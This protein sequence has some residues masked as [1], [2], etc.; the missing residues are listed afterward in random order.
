MKTDRNEVIT[1]SDQFLIICSRG[2]KW[3]AAQKCTDRDSA[4]FC[5][6]RRAA[7]N[8][9]CFK[10]Q[11]QLKW[12]AARLSFMAIMLWSLNLR[13]DL[14]RLPGVIT[15]SA[16]AL[17]APTAA[18]PLAATTGKTVKTHSLQVSS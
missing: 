1:K 5:N 10:I 2:G 12:K 11:T 6:Q 7:R 8:K 4:T 17:N 15:H 14:T 3:S 13:Y 18:A 16:F 9:L